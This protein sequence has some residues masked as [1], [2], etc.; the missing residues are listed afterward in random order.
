MFIHLSLGENFARDVDTDSHVFVD[1]A[2][3]GKTVDAF[4]IFS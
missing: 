4:F 2:L 3:Q 1:D